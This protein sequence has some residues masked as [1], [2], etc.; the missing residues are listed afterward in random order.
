MNEEISE[1]D[2]ILLLSPSSK[3]SGSHKGT[4]FSPQWV[5]GTVWRHFLI[6]TNEGERV[7]LVSIK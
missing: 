2:K 3:V 6:V 1:K 5:F 7:L 4:N